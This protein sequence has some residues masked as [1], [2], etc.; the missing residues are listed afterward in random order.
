MPVQ[1]GERLELR[2]VRRYALLGERR[3]RAGTEPVLAVEVEVLRA[4]REGEQPDARHAPLAADAQAR[5][6]QSRSDPEAPGLRV[7]RERAEDGQAA[8]LRDERRADELAVPR[9]L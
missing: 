7:D 6:E 1:P 2:G 5:V 3:E 8:P 4:L 9:R